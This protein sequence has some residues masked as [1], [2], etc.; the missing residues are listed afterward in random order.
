MDFNKGYSYPLLECIGGIE[1]PCCQ[2]SCRLPKWEAKTSLGVSFVQALLKTLE[3]DLKHQPVYQDSPKDSL[4]DLSLEI[5][6][7]IQFAPNQDP[8]DIPQQLQ[9]G[10]VMYYHPSE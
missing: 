4:L 10:K 2:L 1:F 8:Q 9:L 3:E 7:A 5:E 6:L